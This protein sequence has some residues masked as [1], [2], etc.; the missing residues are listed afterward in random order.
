MSKFEGIHINCAL[1]PS[2]SISLMRS[3]IAL[4]EANTADFTFVEAVLRVPARDDMKWVHLGFE[5]DSRIA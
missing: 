4:S 5:E 3:A 2:S 1:I